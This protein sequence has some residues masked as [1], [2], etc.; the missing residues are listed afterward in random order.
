MLL[1][2]HANI[3]VPVRENFHHESWQLDFSNPFELTVTQVVLRIR[4]SVHLAL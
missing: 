3:V 1:R 2:Y 4:H